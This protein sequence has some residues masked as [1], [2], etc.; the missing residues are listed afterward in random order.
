M[1]GSR[2]GGLALQVELDFVLPAR[3]LHLEVLLDAG[4]EILTALGVL[5]VLD[6]HVDP[7]GEDV[8]AYSLIDDDAQSVRGHVEY[9]AS[10][11]V[12]YFERHTL[13]YCSVTL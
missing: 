4:E 5:D 2:L 10:L 8:S 3:P 9:A 1:R 6:A 13:L 11:S 12:V 7:L